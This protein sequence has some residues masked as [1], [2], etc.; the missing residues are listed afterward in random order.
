MA[1]RFS[2]QEITDLIYERKPLA[3]DL[4][5]SVQFKPK[6]GHKEYGLD[7]KGDRGSNFR[8]ILRESN[9]NQLDFSVILGVLPT[10][11]N[12]LFRLRRYNG[13]SHEHRNAIEGERFYDF[14]IHTATGRYQDFGAREDWYAEPTDRF[15]NIHTALQ[16]MISDCNFDVPENPEPSLPWEV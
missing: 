11:T 1:A 8:L 16:C 2:D 3:R 7:V 15:G 9:S 5:S 4:L 14:H 13:R 10:N 6:L 12:Q